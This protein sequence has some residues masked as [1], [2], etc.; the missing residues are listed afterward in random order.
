L[1]KVRRMTSGRPSPLKSSTATAC[2]LVPPTPV[3]AAIFS[4]ESLDTSVKRD[5]S[6]SPL[7]AVAASAPAPMRRK[8]PN[9]RIMMPPREGT[10]DYF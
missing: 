2:G 6:E 1:P 5:F 9:T 3:L 10:A 4:P 8:R 7:S